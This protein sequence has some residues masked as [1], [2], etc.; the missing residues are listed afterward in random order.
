MMEKAVI[1]FLFFAI[2][3]VISVI[4]IHKK[5]I[6]NETVAV[7]FVPTI[8]SFF[9]FPEISLPSR[10]L[11]A[12]S[13]SGI[14]LFIG[15]ILPGSFGGGDIKMMVPVGMFL[16]LERTLIAGIIAVFGGGIYSGGEILWGVYKTKSWSSVLRNCKT[17]FAFGPM[18]CIGSMMAWFWGDILRRW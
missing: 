12:V 15:V 14:M 10:M 6:Y 18:L 2:L 7:L 11:G 5:K 4:D 3:A 17:R 1:T 8:V 13:V 16:G 9:I